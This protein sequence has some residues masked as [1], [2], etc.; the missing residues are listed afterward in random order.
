MMVTGRK[1]M[2]HQVGLAQQAG[3]GLV[4]MQQQCALLV[5]T[6]VEEEWLAVGQAWCGWYGRGGGR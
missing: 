3:R 4:A 5:G 1:R 6:V 2:G